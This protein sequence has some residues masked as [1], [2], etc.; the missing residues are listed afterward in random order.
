MQHINVTCKSNINNINSLKNY[1]N[2]FGCLKDVMLSKSKKTEN[3]HL[4]EN[5]L[6]SSVDIEHHD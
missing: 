2:D 4:G 6:E 5:V 3:V 1:I